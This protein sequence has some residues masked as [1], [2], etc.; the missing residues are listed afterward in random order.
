[1]KNI[2]LIFAVLAAM[3]P[4]FGDS[5]LDTYRVKLDQKLAVVKREALSLK[6][7]TDATYLEALDRIKNWVQAEG[8]LEKLTVVLAELKRFQ[9]EGTVPAEA[10]KMAE[11]ARLQAG[12]QVEEAKVKSATDVRVT[13]LL[14]QY[15]RALKG[16]Q[17]S[18]VR[19]GKL[20]DATAIQSE[21][22]HAK[23]NAAV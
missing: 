3:T 8:S 4:V 11:I 16:L 21:R 18:R 22:K 1:M 15:D 6:L 20:D 2:S 7:Q 10:S 23:A 13:L 5:Q 19:E 14:S 17:E 9:T 12:Y